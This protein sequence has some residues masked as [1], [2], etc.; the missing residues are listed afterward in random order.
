MLRKPCRIPKRYLFP[1]W[2][3]MFFKLGWPGPM[4]RW[5]GHEEEG[6]LVERRHATIVYVGT[7]T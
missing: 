2:K 6:N 5:S 4:G 1:I 7:T 3:S